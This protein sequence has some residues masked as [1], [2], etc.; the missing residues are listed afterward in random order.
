MECWMDAMQCWELETEG[1]L[2]NLP[3]DGEGT[4]IEGTQLPASQAETQTPGGELDLISRTID[5]GGRPAGIGEGLVSPHC[6]LELD[7][8]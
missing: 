8:S 3:L 4:N 6:L 5:G 1:D 2:I 7:M